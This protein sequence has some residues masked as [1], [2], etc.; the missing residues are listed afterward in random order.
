MFS[1][2]VETD[3]L[4]FEEVMKSHYVAFW[5]E[6]IQ[7]EMDSIMGNNTWVLTGLP[8]GSKPIGC[9]WILRRN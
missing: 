5:K 1:L 6:A 2:H 3:T 7:D 9:K 4:T 8:F